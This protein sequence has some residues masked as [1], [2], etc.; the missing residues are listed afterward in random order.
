MLLDS[1]SR[2]ILGWCVVAVVLLL[3]WLHGNGKGLDRGL[4]RCAPQALPAE[5]DRDCSTCHQER[6]SHTAGKPIDD[7]PP[8]SARIVTT[9]PRA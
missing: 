1:N 8:A 4:S 5:D 3:A 2:S 7:A 9:I 6:A